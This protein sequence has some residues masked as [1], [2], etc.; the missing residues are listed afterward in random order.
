[1]SKAH[2]GAGERVKAQISGGQPRRRP[3]Q[4]RARI[5]VTAILE[6]AERLLVEQGYAA[7]STNAIARRAGVSIG[8]LYQYFPDKEAVFRE[9]L[10]RHHAAMRPLK[11]RAL[12]GLQDP[13]SELAVVIDRILRDALAVRD[14]DSALM[15]A[16]EEELSAVA[17]RWGRP[18]I[19]GGEVSGGKVARAIA[20]RTGLSQAEAAHRAWLASTI[21]ETVGRRL[22]HG[23]L[24]GLDRERLMDLTVAMV[25]RMLTGNDKKEDRHVDP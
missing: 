12:Q 23:E 25:T 5:T 16:L 17:A 9:V 18:D 3:R 7:A 15:R 14:R 4:A 10:N 20:A 8:S 21:L 6:A 24:P 2:P 1:M 19:G 11:E 13:G 22:V